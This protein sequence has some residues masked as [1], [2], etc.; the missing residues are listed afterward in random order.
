MSSYPDPYT[1]TQPKYNAQYSSSAAEFNPYD[2]AQPHRT[3]DQGVI[4]PYAGG[5]R[6]EPSSYPP[7]EQQTRSKEGNGFEE[8]NSGMPRRRITKS[9]RTLR[10]LQYEDEN[11]WTRGGRGRCIGRFCC[12]TVLITIFLLVSIVL[13]LLLWVSPPDITI[14]NVAP[15]TTGSQIQLTNDGGVNINLSVNISVANPNYFS[16]DLTKVKAS[17]FYPI[18]NTPVGG[19]EQDNINFPSH[20]STTFTFP[21]TIQY[22]ISADPN[23]AILTDLATKCGYTGG[24]K[25]NIVVNYDIDLGIRI[26]AVTVSPVISNTF[27]FACP[28]SQSDIDQMLKNAGISLS[29]II[30]S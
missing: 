28:L 23:H 30:G 24:A 20:S 6:D 5:Y 7:I 26:L 22:Q 18:N 25:S 2:N 12:C 29:G 8:E 16:V 14:N 10:A 11:L 17:I 13:T 27:S 3:Y 21:F 4:E 19:G 1:S 9:S 15:P